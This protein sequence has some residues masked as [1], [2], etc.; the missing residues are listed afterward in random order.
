VAG[1]LIEQ[2]FQLHT[3][4]LAIAPIKVGIVDAQIAVSRSPD[5]ASANSPVMVFSLPRRSST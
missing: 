5:F 3:P 2:G 1:R 4:D